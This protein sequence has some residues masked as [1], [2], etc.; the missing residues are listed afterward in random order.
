MYLCIYPSAIANAN[1]SPKEATAVLAAKK[2]AL[3]VFKATV[4]LLF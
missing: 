2:A 1:P 3:A 4:I